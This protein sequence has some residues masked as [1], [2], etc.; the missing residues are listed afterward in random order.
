MSIQETAAWHYLFS[1]WGSW[2]RE[3]G[4]RR[5]DTLCE[6]VSDL[7]DANRDE[8]QTI[9]E[10]VCWCQNY[11]HM[12]GPVLD[13]IVIFDKN[14]WEIDDTKNHA[15]LIHQNLPSA[16]KGGEILI[17]TD[18][19]LQRFLKYCDE[20]YLRGDDFQPSHEINN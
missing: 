5:L 20:K 12:I 4:V 19:E 11:W 14:G 6:V 15:E 17:R 3:N 1:R 18:Y 8:I 13:Y 10:G 7:F 16:A 2:L 9:E